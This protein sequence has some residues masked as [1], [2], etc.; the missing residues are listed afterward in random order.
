MSCLP[1]IFACKDMCD[2][3]LKRQT[4]YERIAAF[5]GTEFLSPKGFRVVKR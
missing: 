5:L 3:I 2:G 4:K 1:T